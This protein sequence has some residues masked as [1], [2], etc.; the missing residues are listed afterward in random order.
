MAR[1]FKRA[2]SPV[3]Y[4]DYTDALGIRRKVALST[5]QRAAQTMLADLLRKVE[6]DRAGLV[7]PFE[8][9]RQVPLADH[10]QAWQESMVHAGRTLKHAKMQ[11]ARASRVL[12][13]ANAQFLRDIVS[14]ERVLSSLSHLEKTDGLSI[15]S[16]NHF[17]GATKAFTRWCLH[18]HRIPHNPLLG[19][20][21]RAGAESDQR[22]PRRILTDEEF[23][24]LVNTADGSRERCGFL[25][26]DRAWL[27]RLAL[28]T[29]FRS[30]ELA[31]LRPSD[32]Q[33]G[34][35]S[36]RLSGKFCKN[37]R[38]AVQ[39]LPAPIRP[40]LAAWLATKRKDAPLWPDL[41]SKRAAGPRILKG[42][43]E[44]ARRAWVAN[45]ATQDERAE[46][47]ANQD[48]LRWEDSQGR[49]LDFH[50]LRHSAVT[51]WARAG[52]RPRELQHLARHC[53]AAFTLS[54]YVM[55]SLHDAR[56]VVDRAN[57]DILGA[58]TDRQGNHESSRKTGTDDAKPLGHLLGHFLGQTGDIPGIVLKFPETTDERKKPGNP[59]ENRKKPVKSQ[60]AGVAESADA[61][62]LKSAPPNPQSK[63]EEELATSPRQTG[64]STGT[65]CP[66]LDEVA[67]RWKDLPDPL[68]AGIL[69]M[70][71]ASA[72]SKPPKRPKR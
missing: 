49:F 58:E 9:H 57:W 17:L 27:Y 16:V 35:E 19:L 24:W 6:R 64:P 50:S 31:A 33:A 26:T 38:D 42:D 30:K 48:F 2:D 40:D 46:R 51:R 32:F 15:A 25:G 10:I 54:K 11:A 70:V 65:S 34:L 43:L 1:I 14:S 20:R 68:K 47:E 37:G 59:E 66:I 62:D 60:Y 71:R 61:S 22:H 53:T 29:G 13:L 45:G 63:S 44:A 39:P 52:A 3:Y 41:I 69:A 28:A 5:D 21:P 18:S 56:A 23:H 8:V 4:G 36:V 12:A 67:D 55:P 72:P 7:D